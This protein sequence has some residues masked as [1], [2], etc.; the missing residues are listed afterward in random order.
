MLGITAIVKYNNLSS[1]V[2]PLLGL[3]PPIYTNAFSTDCP[4]RKENKPNMYG[5][6]NETYIED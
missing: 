5:A 6:Q 4:Y 1:P 2:I 3:F